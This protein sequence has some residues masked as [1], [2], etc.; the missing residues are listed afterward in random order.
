MPDGW[1][2]SE[3]ST[4][5]ASHDFDHPTIRRTTH[6]ALDVPAH[7]SIMSTATKADPVQVTLTGESVTGSKVLP[8]L[9]IG[10]RL[11]AINQR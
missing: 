9:E 5:Q 4:A 1:S 10:V 11:G 2:A 7:D 6:A 8:R 3:T